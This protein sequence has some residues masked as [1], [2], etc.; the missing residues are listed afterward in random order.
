MSFVKAY[1]VGSLRWKRDERTL[2][3]GDWPAVQSDLDNTFESTSPSLLAQK[4]NG[5][6]SDGR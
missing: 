6:A 2:E 5:S 4:L 3:F 1:Q